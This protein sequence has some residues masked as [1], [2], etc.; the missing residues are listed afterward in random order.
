MKINLREKGITLIEGAQYYLLGVLI[1]GFVASN[2]AVIPTLF[3]LDWTNVQSFIEFLRV[4]L[5]WVIALEVA[6]LLIDYR[7]EIIIELLIFVV[8]RKILLLE[9]DYVSLFIGII[10][11]VIL[12]VV[13]QG[14]KERKIKNSAEQQMPT[15]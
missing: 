14:L 7:T 15:V 3:D 4:I 10:G 5:L 2:V 9:N 8:A 11:V 13:R 12:L 6:R 1:I